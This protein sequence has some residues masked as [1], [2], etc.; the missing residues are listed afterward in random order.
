MVVIACDHTPPPAARVAGSAERD[1]ADGSDVPVPLTSASVAPAAKK[2][3]PVVAADCGCVY[4]C[5]TG[6]QTGPDKWSVV[7]PIWAPHTLDAKV[8]RWC[9][10]SDCTDAFH[11][12]IVC[13]GVCAPKPADHTCHF[14]GDR[15]VSAQKP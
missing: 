12:Q 15:C 2:C 7:H 4:S 3:L 6:T 14:E 5:G 10:G 11:A 9:V 13:D 1:G 8:S